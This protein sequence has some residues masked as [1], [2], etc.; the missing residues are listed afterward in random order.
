MRLIAYVGDF[1][2]ASEFALLVALVN[3]LHV[4]V[5]LAIRRLLVVDIAALFVR[6]LVEFELIAGIVV[7]IDLVY[8]IIAAIVRNDVQDD[9]GFTVGCYVPAAVGS[10]G[11]LVKITAVLFGMDVCGEGAAG[12]RRA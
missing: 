5:E 2:I 11:E 7:E 1:R 12:E 9:I 6:I 8:L 10:A 3:H 4:V